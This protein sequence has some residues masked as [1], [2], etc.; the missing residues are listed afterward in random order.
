MID[1][2]RKIWLQI[3]LG[4]LDLAFE[5]LDAAIHW[6]DS[7][8]PSLIGPTCHDDIER[9]RAQMDRVKRR[10]RNLLTDKR[11]SANTAP[12]SKRANKKERANGGT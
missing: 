8:R 2:Q 6:F 9:F 5:K 1:N 3:G 11:T 10:A 4:N 12:R 7:A